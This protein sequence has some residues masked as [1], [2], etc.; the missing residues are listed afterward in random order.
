MRVKNHPYSL[1]L[2]PRIMA[3]IRRAA[4]LKTIEVNQNVSISSYVRNILADGIQKIESKA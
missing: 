2:D 4:A 3:R 1:M